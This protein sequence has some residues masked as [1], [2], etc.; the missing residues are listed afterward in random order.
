MS[1]KLQPISM[2]WKCNLNQFFSKYKGFVF[3][4]F[5]VGVL[6]LAISAYSSN[7]AVAQDRTL[8]LKTRQDAIQ[9]LENARRTLDAQSNT[10]NR[11]REPLSLSSCTKSTSDKSETASILTCTS[12]TAAGQDECLERAN[13]FQA[14]GCSCSSIEGG[15]SCDCPDGD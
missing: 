14:Q 8:K 2:N 5:A 13:N 12:G 9:Q 1:K 3:T 10:I 6:L 7:S 15:T 11:S 4:L